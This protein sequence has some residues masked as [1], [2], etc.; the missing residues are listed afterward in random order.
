[1]PLWPCRFRGREAVAL[2]VLATRIGFADEQDLFARAVAGHQD[3]DG[4]GLIDAGEIEEIAVLP[5]LVV[6]VGE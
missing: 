2:P 5:V 1:M 6:D 3:E 4:L